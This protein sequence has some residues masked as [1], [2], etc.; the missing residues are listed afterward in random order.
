MNRRSF[1]KQLI[2]TCAAATI[3]PAILIE[4]KKQTVPGIDLDAPMCWKNYVATYDPDPELLR[5]FRAAFE[6]TRF[7][8]PVKR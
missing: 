3:A 7:L 2:G 8:S 1:L 5:K 6:N 4:T